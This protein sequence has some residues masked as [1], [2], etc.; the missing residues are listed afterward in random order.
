MAAELNTHELNHNSDSIDLN[1]Q[2]DTLKY[3]FDTET[4][5]SID[6]SSY[7]DIESFTDNSNKGFQYKNCAMHINIQSLPAKLESLK[8]MLADLSEKNIKL[9]YLMLCETFLKDNTSHLFEIPGYTLVC[10]NRSHNTRGGGVA[11]YVN[12][13]YN[14]EVRD[15]LSVFDEGKFESLFIEIKSRSQKLIIGEIYRVPNTNTNQS[16]EYYESIMNK[17]SNYK[18]DIIIG[19]D[20]NFDLLK[21]DSHNK[22]SEL[23]DIFITNRFLPCITK[24]TRITHSSATLIDNIYI[25]LPGLQDIKS[26]ILVF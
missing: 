24:P 19:T 22:T 2:A 1:K 7:I 8:S 5:C 11:I 4:I 3:C 13:L 16:L 12:E 17:L 26:G 6:S 9:D 20:Q 15:D 21:I 18:N 14:Y 25:S 10:K 23:L